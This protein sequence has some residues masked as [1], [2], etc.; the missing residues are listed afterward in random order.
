MA[1]LRYQ[2]I[3]KG[4]LIFP[5]SHSMGEPSIETSIQIYAHYCKIVPARNRT[6]TAATSYSFLLLNVF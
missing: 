5:S 1:A 6:Q 3:I 4:L 2:T